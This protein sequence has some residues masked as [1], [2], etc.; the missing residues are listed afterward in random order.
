LFSISSFLK[1]DIFVCLRRLCWE[2]NC[3]ISTMYVWVI[4]WIGPFLLFS[5]FLPYSSHM[6]ISTGL[7]ICIHS[8][9]VIHQI[10]S[11]A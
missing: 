5:S 10:Y 6:V 4:T 3:G 9:V 8:C 1:Q 7:K 2:F 11:A